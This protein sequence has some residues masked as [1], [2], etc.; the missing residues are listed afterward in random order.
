[1]IIKKYFKKLRFYT[2]HR[3]QWPSLEFFFN[4]KTFS[5]YLLII[6]YFKYLFKYELFY[7]FFGKK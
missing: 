6:L 2:N 7:N 5:A 3:I 4:K 1:M